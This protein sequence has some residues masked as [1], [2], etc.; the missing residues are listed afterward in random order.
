MEIFF[1]RTLVSDIWAGTG[2]LN[3][4]YKATK[5]N[6]VICVTYD[7]VSKFFCKEIN[8]FIQQ[9]CIKLITSDR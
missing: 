5:H 2:Y 8:V 3:D 9:K 1:C 6:F 4:I 7:K